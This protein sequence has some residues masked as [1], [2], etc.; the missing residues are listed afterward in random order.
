MLLIL[1]E[2]Q[3][4]RDYITYIEF[5]RKRENADCGFCGKKKYFQQKET[6]KLPRLFRFS[7]FS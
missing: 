5:F 1:D 2:Y 7:Y 4:L 6:N 3:F